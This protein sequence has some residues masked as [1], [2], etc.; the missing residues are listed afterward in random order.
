MSETV[1]IELPKDAADDLRRLCEFFGRLSDDEAALVLRNDVLS[2]PGCDGHAGTC[3]SRCV[4]ISGVVRGDQ[5]RAG[6]CGMSAAVDDAASIGDVE[7]PRSAGQ[8]DRAWPRPRPGR[9][10]R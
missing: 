10:Q 3:C 6:G 5:G 9:G 4:D 1:L 2:G 7:L 8:G